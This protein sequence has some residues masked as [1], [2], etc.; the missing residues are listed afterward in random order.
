MSLEL[1]A[2]RGGLPAA[3]VDQSLRQALAA[4]DAARHN[5]LLWFHEILARSLY[6]ELGYASIE[7]YATEASASRATAPGSS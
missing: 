4:F 5:A 1:P 2:F 3:R 6:R 7:Q